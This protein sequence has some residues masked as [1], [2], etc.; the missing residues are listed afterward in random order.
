[1]IKSIL[2]LSLLLSSAT[3]LAQPSKVVTARLKLEDGNLNDAVMTIDQAIVHEKSKGDARAWELRGDIYGAFATS[4]DEKVDMTAIAIYNAIAESY[5]RVDEIKEGVG[6]SN[7]KKSS[8]LYGNMA[9]NEGVKN[10]KIRDYESA[11]SLFLTA[12]TLS[13]INDFTDSLA[14]Y[15]VALASERL[16]DYATAAEYYRKCVEIGYRSETMYSFL[17][18]AYNKLGD[19]SSYEKT[20]RE[21]VENY[22]N[23]SNLI[24]AMLNVKLSNSDFEGAL[25]NLN[26]L[27][28][29]DP[30][31]KLLHFSQGTV[32]DNLK[33]TDAAIVSYKNAIA[34][35]PSYFDAKYNLGALYFNQGVE[36]NNAANEIDDKIGF[37]KA[38]KEADLK[39]FEAKSYLE[40]AREIKP[41]DR[42]TLSSLK[43]LYARTGET[44]KYNEVKAALEN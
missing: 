33:R 22:P 5:L 20:L 37:E 32:L 35:D 24:T 4:S 6:I 43:Q 27:V 29:L 10:F 30:T 7:V 16:E 40:K 25:N 41:D 19:V 36:L 1:M 28:E 18:L 39:F 42:N 14:L 21:G 13:G 17:A 26:K 2:L 12:I 3:G 9:L 38:R 44:E 11:R 8:S 15:D 31:N 34:L 23:N